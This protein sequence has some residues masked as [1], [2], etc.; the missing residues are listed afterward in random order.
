MDQESPFTRFWGQMVRWLAN[1][2]VEMKAEAGITAHTDKAYYEPDSPIIITAAVR[3]KEGEGTDEADVTAMVKTPQGPSDSVTLAPV[4][5]S[6]GT[7]QGTFEP[8]RP[9]TYEIEVGAK[10][11]GLVLQAEK[12]SAEVGRPNLEFDRLDLDDAM[13][14]KIASATGGRYLHISTAD[15]LIAELDRQEHRQHVSLEQPLFFPRIFWVLFVG[16]LAAEWVLR[17]RF[18]LR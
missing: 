1:R 16:L 17:R 11:S 7:Y 5:G 10:V 13:L 18:Q 3:N 8:K 12:T 15:E 2:T 6:A 14:K 9:G 4:P